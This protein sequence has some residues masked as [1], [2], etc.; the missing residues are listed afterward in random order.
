MDLATATI[1]DL[2]RMVKSVLEVPPDDGVAAW[3]A[4]TAFVRTIGLALD[5]RGL[6]GDSLIRHGLADLFQ[7]PIL[8]SVAVSLLSEA[9]VP[10]LDRLEVDPDLNVQGWRDAMKLQGPRVNFSEAMS[11]A[12]YLTQGWVT[13][14]PLE[15]LVR[16]QPVASEELDQWARSVD[17]SSRAAAATYRWAVLR[18]VEPNLENWDS[19][20]L[21]KEYRHTVMAV[22]AELPA[23]LIAEASLDKDELAHAVARKSLT[24]DEVRVQAGWNDVREAVVKQAKMLLRQGRCAEAAALF[25]FLL[26]QAPADSWLR[27]NFAFC[28]ITTRP[29]DA[30]VFLRDAQRL[31]YKPISLL[32]YN[33]ACCAGTE[34]QK[35]EVLFDANR[36][37]LEDLESVPVPAFIW[38]R[39]ANAPY[40]FQTAETLDVRADLGIIAASLATELGEM[41]RADIWQ[42]RVAELGAIAS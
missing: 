22:D 35:R 42:K 23:S 16:M 36:H 25:E 11:H 39:P 26:G 20:S 19:T 4:R 5:R 15:T 37:W 40:D 1:A 41:D 24:E 3:D 9:Q 33:R 10:G 2:L 38:R 30:Y 32:L 8:G 18:L 21:R 13:F 34:T 12:L 6:D 14:A 31:S 28:L 29:G 17:E 27:N 7:A